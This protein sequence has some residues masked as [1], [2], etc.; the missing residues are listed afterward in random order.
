MTL[1]YIIV[2]Q[3][4]LSCYPIKVVSDN[5]RL[6]NAVA[7]KNKL[8]LWLYNLIIA[9]ECIDTIIFVL[10]CGKGQHWVAKI[11]AI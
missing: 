3:N 9:V 2:E 5:E 11:E 1:W 10:K 7:L 8:F 4:N 6:H